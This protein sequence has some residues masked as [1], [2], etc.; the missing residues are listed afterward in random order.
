MV[1]ENKPLVTVV[2]VTHNEGRYLR[3]SM[4]AILSQSNTDF[5]VVIMDNGSE[6]DTQEY[7]A[8]ITDPRVRSYRNENLGLGLA[9]NI[10]IQNAKG[11]WIALGN[12]DDLWYQHKLAKQ[13]NAF[14]EKTAVVFTQAELIDDSGK[15][16]PEEIARTFPFS[17]DN[18][19]PVKMFERLFFHTNFLCAPSAIIQKDLLLKHPFDPMLIQLQDFDMWAHLIKTHEFHIIQE[20]LTG[21]RVRLDGSNISLNKKNRSRV[22]LE[23]G[24]V[25]ER[26][27]DGI[28]HEFFREAFKDHLRRPQFAGQIEFEFEKAFLY[29][30]LHEP[31]VKRI[32]LTRFYELMSKDDSRKVGESVYGISMRDVWSWCL[33][34]LYADADVL[35][36]SGGAH[37]ELLQ[38]LK[39]TKQEL[40]QMKETMSAITSG[41]FWKLRE[42]VYSVL[43]KN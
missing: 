12:A 39:S 28:E 6:D 14:N 1:D 8:T 21:Y 19:A 23:L 29:L 25:Y 13:V 17:F 42:K 36:E 5:E 33:S 20:K 2:M 37:I 27:F 15:A 32:G 35:K 30:K 38:E 24:V 18:R 22:L 3:E 4:P 43:R 41:K 11:S 34:P 9:Y 7:I 26:I 16:I 10:G 31:A 40:A